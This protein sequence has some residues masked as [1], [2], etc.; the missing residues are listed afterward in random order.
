MF[1]FK[2]SF[3]ASFSTASVPFGSDLACSQKCLEELAF[4]E[5]EIVHADH[6][7]CSE[8]SA[9]EVEQSELSSRGV[10]IL[11]VDLIDSSLILIAFLEAKSLLPVVS[12]LLCL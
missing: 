3:R 9:L 7:L 6:E 11:R 2:L 10:G 4:F 1:V 12:L 5:L 8:R